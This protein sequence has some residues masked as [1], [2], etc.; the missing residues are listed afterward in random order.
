MM[1]GWMST[2]GRLFSAT[3]IGD[4]MISGA[5]DFLNLFLNM[6]SNVVIVVIVSNP[7]V[8]NGKSG[9]G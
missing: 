3:L 7:I 9:W 5:K 1:T 4:S 8:A 6:A 2:A